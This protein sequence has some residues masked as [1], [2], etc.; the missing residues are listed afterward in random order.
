M[1]TRHYKLRCFCNAF[2]G[3]SNN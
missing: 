1:S 2:L 3:W